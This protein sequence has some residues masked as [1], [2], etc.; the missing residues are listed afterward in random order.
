MTPTALAQPMA[1][2]SHDVAVH[3]SAF[4]EWLVGDLLARGDPRV[5]VVSPLHFDSGH[6]DP[7]GRVT[8]LC[9]STR[10][11]DDARADADCG[12]AAGSFY[13][14]YLHRMIAIAMPGRWLE[15]ARH[16]LRPGGRVVA[17]VDPAEFSFAP[18]P[19]GGDAQ[20]LGRILIDA[21]FCRVELLQRALGLIIATAHR[22]ERD[23][24]R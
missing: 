6:L 5:L 12:F 2:A 8:A 18:L 19:A 17:A 9:R 20:L 4:E 21:G 11:G 15:R 10:E 7:G 3:P 22:D 23:R 24:T 1:R 13:A 16:L 14:V